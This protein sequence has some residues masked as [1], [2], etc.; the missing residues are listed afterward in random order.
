MPPL[1]HFVTNSTYFLWDVLTTAY[2]GKPEL[3]KKESQKVSVITDGP[4]QGRTFKSDEGRM[5]NIINDVDRDG[6]FDYMID[7]A[8]KI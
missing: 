7:L 2:V 3:V 1:T 8:K 5:I 4:S 6:F